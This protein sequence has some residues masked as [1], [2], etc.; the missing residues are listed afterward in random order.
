M[1]RRLSIP[2][3]AG[4]RT[5]HDHERSVQRQL[6]DLLSGAVRT[7]G[8]GE[9]TLFELRFERFTR[10]IAR[11]RVRGV[12]IGN[13]CVTCVVHANEL[14]HRGPPDVTEGFK[15]YA[16]QE[17]ISWVARLPRRWEGFR[18]LRRPPY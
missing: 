8:H 18:T 14:R 12:P 10:L 16:A 11:D 4:D 9:V 3:A 13:D 1:N 7:R 15:C 17:R 2:S 6:T 5:A